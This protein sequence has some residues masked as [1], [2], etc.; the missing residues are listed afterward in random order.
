[1]FT[2]CVTMAYY[3]AITLNPPSIAAFHAVVEKARAAGVLTVCRKASRGGQHRT[4][5]T[6][7][8]ALSFCTRATPGR[9]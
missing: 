3:N 9:E 6:V 5:N 7:P 1:M 4:G 2:V 8:L